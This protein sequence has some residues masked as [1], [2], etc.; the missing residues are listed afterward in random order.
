MTDIYMYAKLSPLERGR[1]RGSMQALPEHMMDFSNM[2]TE[3]G[4]VHEHCMVMWLQRMMAG[5]TQATLDKL[6]ILQLMLISLQR[7]AQS[8]RSRPKQ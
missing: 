2:A 8:G 1:S 5:L 7:N 6:G 4:L 3:D